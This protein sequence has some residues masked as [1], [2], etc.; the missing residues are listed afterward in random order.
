MSMRRPAI[1]AL[2][3]MTMLASPAHSDPAADAPHLGTPMSHDD[4][5]K[6]DLTIFPDGRGLPP[7]HGTAKEGRQHLR[8][9]MRELS[10]RRGSRC[11]G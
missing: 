2:T 6:W 8:A 10:W 1:A 4:V 7:G 9:E 3:A 5:A 11:N